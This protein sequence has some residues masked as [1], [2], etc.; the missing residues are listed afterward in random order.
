M[1][2]HQTSLRRALAA[3]LIHVVLFNFVSLSALPS[4]AQSVVPEPRR[5]HLLN[6]LR[7]LLSQRPGDAK[8]WMRLRVHSGAAFDLANKEGTMALLS[9]ALFPDPSTRQYVTEELG[10]QLDVHT[11][12]DDIEITVGGNA[13]EFDRMAELLRNALLQMR[14]TPEDVQ[15][16]KDARLKA[17]DPSTQ[18]TAQLADRA[19]RARLFGAHPY[20]RS[21]EGTIDSLARINRGDLMFARERFLNPN[22]STLVVVGNFD[23]QRAMRTFRQ[24]FGPWRK[25]ETIAPATFRQPEAP[26]ARALIV[27]AAPGTRETQVRVAARGVARSDRDRAAATL[28]TIVARERWRASLKDASIANVSVVHESNAVSGLFL[29]RA[30]APVTAAASALESARAALRSFAS[31]PVGN[32]ELDRAMREFNA[33]DSTQHANEF[34]FVNVWLDSITYGYDASTDER[35]ANSVTA[36]DLQRVAARLFGEGQF[37]SIIVG[38]AS[39]LR[40][41]LSNLAGGVEVAGA[42]SAAPHATATPPAQ[43]APRRP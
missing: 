42:K 31:K 26:D 32:D 2:F 38:D 4:R 25:S 1:N 30:T 36:A 21:V 9:D 3:A 39:E 23:P 28:L 19:V 11:T 22:N 15:R 5:E 6:G 34:P 8:V 37:A 13:S 35:A 27:A 12:Y 24:F 43:P 18:T 17:L 14:L 29:M 33:S 7:V 10:G 40:A 41:A 20:G 16:M